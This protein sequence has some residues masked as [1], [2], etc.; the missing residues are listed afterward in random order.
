MAIGEARFGVH[1]AAGRS[2]VVTLREL[3]HWAPAALKAEAR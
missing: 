1:T 3:L 2:A